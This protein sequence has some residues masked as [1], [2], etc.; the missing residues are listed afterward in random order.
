MRQNLQS[1]KMGLAGLV[2]LA[3]AAS[4]CAGKK[5]PETMGAVSGTISCRTDIE[6]SPKAVAFVRLA[7]MTDGDVGGK[8]VV[9]KEIKDFA[10]AASTP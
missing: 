8:T 1:V 5:P 6:L 3:A 10:S 9:Q 7:D 4:G 2:M